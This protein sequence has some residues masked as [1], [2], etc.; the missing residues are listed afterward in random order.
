MSEQGG[1]GRSAWAYSERVDAALR[2]AAVA[3][4]GQVRKGSDVPYVMHPFHVGLILD[5]YGFGEDVVIAGILHDVLEDPHYEDSTVQQRLQRSCPALEQA[6]AD[7]DGFKEAVI[8]HLRATFGQAVLAL[9][10]HVTE[11]KVDESGTRRPWTVRKHEQLA[12]LVEAP[13]EVCAIKGADCLH[14]LRAMAR[15]LR[16]Q[17]ERAM[18]RFKAGP[19]EIIWYNTTVVACVSTRLGPDGPFARELATALAEFKGAL[20]TC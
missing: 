9:V 10:S 12:A 14:N 11:R 16:D 1:N 20:A 19:A 5:R 3:H 13:V 17:G 2:F 6:P 18:T 15:D 8:V 7:G 4:H